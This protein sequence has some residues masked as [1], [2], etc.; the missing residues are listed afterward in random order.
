MAKPIIY[1]NGPISHVRLDDAR[2]WRY[3]L[4]REYSDKYDFLDPTEID[5]EESGNILTSKQRV[6]QYLNWINKSDG[7][8][9][10]MHSPSIG[11][12]ISLYHAQVM[13]IPTVTVCR[14]DY[15]AFLYHYSLRIESSLDD[16]I[17][18][19]ELFLVTLCRPDT[20]AQ[21]LDWGP[22]DLLTLVREECSEYTNHKID[23][24]STQGE[25]LR[26]FYRQWID[27]PDSVRTWETE[28]SILCS[29]FMDNSLPL[30]RLNALHDKGSFEDEYVNH[31]LS[32]QLAYARME[33]S[34]LEQH[35]K[36]LEATNYGM[37][38]R[39]KDYGRTA[40]DDEVTSDSPAQ[41]LY[42]LGY[43]SILVLSAF[44]NDYYY[45]ASWLDDDY[46]TCDYECLKYEETESW[47]KCVKDRPWLAD[48]VVYL[49]RGG[50]KLEDFRGVIESKC[51]KIIN[52]ATASQAIIEIASF[53][54]S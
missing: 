5:V 39:L 19:M 20:R 3:Y 45:I 43:E 48:L 38:Q 6:L 30:T 7:I 12:A 34:D 41:V 44:E 11:T 54:D 31:T 25:V 10:N 1:L 37:R 35:V 13:G 16:A 22:R 17:A 23:A 15:S 26:S 52:R 9:T 2:L 42:K 24:L 21:Y 33:C 51:K 32:E 27:L 40:Q 46:Y 50:R 49:F 14:E 47:L 36:A 8:I 29:V 53:R 4:K 28:Y 18:M